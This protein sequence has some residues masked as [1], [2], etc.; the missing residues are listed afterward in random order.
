MGSM[1]GYPFCKHVKPRCKCCQNKAEGGGLLHIII[2]SQPGVNA[3]CTAQPL[4]FREM[5]IQKMLTTAQGSNTS[6]SNHV[7][8]SVLVTLTGGRE[9]KSE[10]SVRM[11]RYPAAPF[12]AGKESSSHR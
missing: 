9:A 10:K 7:L 6:L 11:L 4:L 2:R 1:S 12:Q 8:D 3:I 5:Y